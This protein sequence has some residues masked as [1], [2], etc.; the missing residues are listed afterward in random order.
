[1]CENIQQLVVFS[2]IQLH[3]IH[4]ILLTVRDKPSSRQQTVR[5][6]CKEIQ[7]NYTL[8]QQI[9][10]FVLPSL[11]ASYAILATSFK[12]IYKYIYFYIIHYVTQVKC[13][14]DVLFLQR[15]ESNFTS[16]FIMLN[17]QF[18]L[19]KMFKSFNVYIMMNN[20]IKFV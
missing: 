3:N 11:K 1:M 19:F 6:T 16:I 8:S 20:Y 14:I 7:L 2:I 12:F 18:Q 17:K 9:R 5:K 13:V 4:D 15:L 10:V